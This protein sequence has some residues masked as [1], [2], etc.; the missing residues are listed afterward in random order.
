MSSPRPLAG[1]YAFVRRVPGTHRTLI[2]IARDRETGR[3]VVASVLPGPRAAGLEPAL[4]LD[5]PHAASLL[6][7][8]E[9]PS[10]EEIPEE[11]PLLPD[12]RVAVAEYVEG[13]SL[14]DRLDAGPI[15]VESAVDWVQ[16]VA[17]VLTVLHNHA[18]VHGAIS[19]KT[20]VV[21]RPNQGSVPI[22]AHLISP[23]SGAYCSPERVTG[24]GPSEADDT[25]ALAVVLYTAL[26]RHT[27]FHGATR[28]ELARAIVRGNPPPIHGV[29][30]GF[31][32]ILSRAL[33]ADLERRFASAAEFGAALRIWMERA[34]RHNL[35]NFAP[36]TA[37][38]G[39]PEPIHTVGDL[40]LAAAFALPDTR[41]ALA[42]FE[43]AEARPPESDRRLASSAPPKPFVRDA[44][45]PPVAARR[46]RHPLAFAA[47]LGAAAIV[48]GTVGI[49]AGRW[50][51]ASPSPAVPPAEL[52]E[53]AAPVAG[54]THPAPAPEP[55]AVAPA[56]SAA[57]EKV[58]VNACIRS[59]LPEGMFDERPQFG[60]LC[61]DTELWSAT[62]RLNG[63]VARFGRGEGLD[64]W[65][66]I[67]RYDLA[68]VAILRD[69]C[70]PTAAPFIVATPPK[71]C[72]SLDVTVHAIAD[73]PSAS[74]ADAYSASVDCLFTHQV[75]YPDEFW[76]R[77]GPKDARAAFD[78]FLRELRAR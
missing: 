33:S 47:T 50:R 5:H 56:P 19:T 27:P 29:D 59:T 75:K 41:E 44:S 43:S 3:L 28:T 49:L 62:R 37:V 4:F 8:L 58:D 11:E 74:S 35:G 15:T 71:L 76:N 39:P 68:A 23:P 36:V 14:Q 1:R 57:L 38:V 53:A 63:Q 26:S 10:P 32:G 18:A 73:D 31:G 55:S 16:S 64:T 46:P 13:R 72:D 42:P 21:V 2:W 48:S 7:V 78:R 65:A 51:H 45:A 67:G 54:V 40:S 52:S 20:V 9:A 6:S 77:V 69:R 25:W 61:K 30:P 66:R 24:S 60:A 70:C 17:D 34:G 12:N 22:L